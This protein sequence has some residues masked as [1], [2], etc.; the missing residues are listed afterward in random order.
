MTEVGFG[1]FQR[2]EFLVFCMWVQRAILFGPSF[3]ELYKVHMQTKYNFFYQKVMKQQFYKNNK[4]C[5]NIFELFFIL[6]NHKLMQNAFFF[7]TWL[8]CKF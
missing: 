5:K 6:R 7:W 2:D 8:C 4:T 1:Y 3:N